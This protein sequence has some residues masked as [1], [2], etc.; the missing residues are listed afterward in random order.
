M[1]CTQRMCFQ[2]WSEYISQKLTSPCYKII[3]IKKK[4]LIDI[5]NEILTETF[6]YF[7]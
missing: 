1:E 4:N 3:I 5:S 2:S 7:R 6:V